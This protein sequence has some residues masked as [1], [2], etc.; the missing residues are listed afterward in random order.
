MIKVTFVFAVLQYKKIS[1]DVSTNPIYCSNYPF[2]YIIWY[3]R[4]T[5]GC[6]WPPW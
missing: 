6:L 3:Y 4:P 5:I 1:H 2:F